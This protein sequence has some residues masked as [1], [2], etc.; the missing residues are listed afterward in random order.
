MFSTKRISIRKPFV[1]PL[2]VG[3]GLITAGI[4]S[5]VLTK[6]YGYLWL[7]FSGSF[8]LMT[9]FL[10]G[11]QRK[12]KVMKREEKEQTKTKATEEGTKEKGKRV[13]NYCPHCGSKIKNNEHFCASC[14]EEI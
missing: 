7:V 8:P 9:F 1:F 11:I 4:V 12:N 6:E 13:E 2:L 3:L 5:T 10:W 14:G